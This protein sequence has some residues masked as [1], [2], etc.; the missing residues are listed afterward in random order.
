MRKLIESANQK[1]SQLS[2]AAVLKAP[3]GKVLDGFIKQ[4]KPQ[5]ITR[6][7]TESVTRAAQEVHRGAQKSSTLMRKAV[8]KPV[9]FAKTS[10]ELSPVKQSANNQAKKVRDLRLH[11]AN[12]IKRSPSIVK[13]GSFPK[14]KAR[15]S[16]TT[17]PL[18]TTPNNPKTKPTNTSSSN[19]TLPSQIA[20]AS[21][22]QLERLLDHALHKADAHKKALH[23][24][25]YKHKGW[26]RV[27]NTPRRV[28]IGSVLVAVLVIGGFFA[29]QNIPQ[30]SMRLA[31][32]KAN[33]NASVPAY[34]PPG[35]SFEG[36]IGYTDRAVTI[37]FT[38]NSG[39]GRTFKMTQEPST[40]TATSLAVNTLTDDT[41]V[42]TAQVNGTTVYIYGEDNHATSVNNGIRYTIE[43]KAK[44]NAEQILKIADSVQ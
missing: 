41:N 3:P 28:S 38:S 23:G 17:I 30:V 31:A 42:Q 37:S 34:T 19:V 24:Q 29:W 20:S 40:E 36:P 35:F 13:F 18:A 26:R 43:D 7:A 11:R 10:T 4:A 44:L 2:T 22:Q 16:Q 25:S 5:A 33:F 32:E 21:H 9:Q 15:T 6:V 27:L 8:K 14:S 39:D 1:S 12:V